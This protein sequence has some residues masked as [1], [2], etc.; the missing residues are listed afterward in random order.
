MP[1]VGLRGMFFSLCYQM[2]YL[3]DAV[4]IGGESNHVSEKQHQSSE[5][6][7][8]IYSNDYICKCNRQ[9]LHLIPLT[10]ERS[11]Q[12]IDRTWSYLPMHD[13][14]KPCMV[15]PVHALSR[16][17]MHGLIH[18]CMVARSRCRTCMVTQTSLAAKFETHTR[19]FPP[20]MVILRD[21][22][23]ISKHRLLYKFVHGLPPFSRLTFV[24]RMDT[25]SVKQYQCFKLKWR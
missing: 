3:M 5:S 18:P 16:L 19:D 1:N 12:R 11:R 7:W 2:S 23:I 10:C 20:C 17:T 21:Q 24:Y 22:L 25:S 6:R 13:N 14:L 15:L 8:D 9:S 4:I